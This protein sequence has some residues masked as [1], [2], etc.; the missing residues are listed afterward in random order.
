MRKHLPE[1]QSDRDPL[2][3]LQCLLVDQLKRTTRD[4]AAMNAMLQIR[5][6]AVSPD[7]PRGESREPSRLTPEMPSDSQMSLQRALRTLTGIRQ[8]YEVGRHVDADAHFY[9][10]HVVVDPSDMAWITATI[11]AL[12]RV[13]ADAA[14]DSDRGSTPREIRR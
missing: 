11:E 7:S 13:I 8:R 4:L 5:N 10:V 1:D 14:T 9:R 12:E 6:D 3:P 2:H